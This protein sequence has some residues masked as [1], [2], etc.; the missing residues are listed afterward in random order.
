MVGIALESLWLLASQITQGLGVLSTNSGALWQT[1]V[2]SGDAAAA[3]NNA[4]TE[5]VNLSLLESAPVLAALVGGLPVT[6]RR[7]RARTAITR[8]IRPETAVD[9]FA[10][11]L[12]A[13][14]VL[15]YASRLPVH[16]QLT[17]RYLFP[18]FPLGVYLLAR[19]PVVRATLTENWRLFTWTTVV[20]ILVGGQLLAV[21]VFWTAV[22]LGEAFQ[23]H[24]LLA[25]GTAT[26]LAAWSLLGRSDD[27]FGHAGAVLL[28]V[29]TGLST[30]FVLLVALEYY[31]IGDSHLLPMVR[32]VAEQV[33][34]L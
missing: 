28:G 22:G 17:V 26:P 11:L 25:L 13:T 3:L 14:L 29:A 10:L 24:A 12:C 30:V 33:D 8:R 1:L 7:L 20:T 15:Q 23:L 34:L 5:S 21:A 4:G 18:L 9:L 16:A 2:R 27:R 19:L 32:V 31:S 6:W